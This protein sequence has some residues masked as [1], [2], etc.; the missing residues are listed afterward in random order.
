MGKAVSTQP[1][2][3]GSFQV[4]L[5]YRAPPSAKVVPFLRQLARDEGDVGMTA[6]PAPCKINPT[7]PALRPIT[8][9]LPPLLGP[10]PTLFLPGP[11]EMSS[12]QPCLQRPQPK[13]HAWT[14]TESTSRPTGPRYTGQLP[15]TN[16]VKGRQVVQSI[17]H[18]LLAL[19]LIT[20]MASNKFYI[21][22]KDLH[23]LCLN[24]MC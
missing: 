10:K 22:M 16:E 21:E 15:E 9:G 7:S 5:H 17:R 12:L 24:I 4:S 13:A 20:V 11:C 18:R 14:L 1:A 19:S 23:K 6:T 3:V 8:G 2:T